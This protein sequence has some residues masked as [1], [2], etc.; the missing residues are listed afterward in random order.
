MQTGVECLGAVG[1]EEMVE[2]IGLAAES[3]AL[4][5]DAYV[6]NLSSTAVLEELFAELCIPT[7][8]REAI[9]SALEEKNGPALFALLSDLELAESAKTS[10]RTFL[11]FTGTVDAFLR[12]M[13]S[14]D[15]AQGE[16]GRSFTAVLNELAKKPYADRLRIDFSVGGD[17]NYYSGIVFKG[18]LSTIPEAVLSG[19]RYD[20]LMHK[21][22]R[23]SKAAGF[24]VYTDRLDRLDG[25]ESATPSDESEWLNVALPKGRLGERV[26][27]IFAKAGYECPSL[28]EPNRKLIFENLQRHVRYFWVK[29]SDVPIYVERGAADIGVAGKDIL[30]EYEPDVFELLDLGVG[31]CRMAIAG[32]KTFRDDPEKTLRVATKFPSIAKA[33]YR[34]KGRDIDIIKLNGSIEIAP[35]LGLSDVIADIVETGKTL[36]END[37]I[38]WEEIVPISARLIANKSAYAFKNTRIRKM[39]EAVFTVSTSGKDREVTE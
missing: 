38:V 2:V 12:D 14:L 35:I 28:L 6:L 20:R 17:A 23:K 37:L 4:L 13:A 34:S 26:Y 33:Y 27:E 10:L 25:R 30:L 39:E 3:L 22:G 7:D 15:V 36:R 11:S 31:K 32:P 19:G 21:L 8:L 29:P 18:Y 16:A 24:A 1:T 9:L 5:S